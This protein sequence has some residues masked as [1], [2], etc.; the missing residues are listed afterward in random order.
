MESARTRKTLDPTALITLDGFDIEVV[1]RGG[2]GVG[3]VRH[4]GVI[5]R[6]F[7]ALGACGWRW[8]VSVGCSASAAEGAGGPGG[9]QW[10]IRVPSTARN[11]AIQAGW[12][13]QAGAVTKGPSV[14]A[15][16]TGMLAYFAPANSTST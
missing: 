12:A 9:I 13:G 10:V 15:W 5:S 3:R 8:W 6:A 2:I 16:S 11:W 14:T 7:C 4:T 1:I